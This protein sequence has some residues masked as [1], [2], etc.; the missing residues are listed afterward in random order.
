M[1]LTIG[2]KMPGKVGTSSVKLGAVD[3]DDDKS[4]AVSL[5]RQCDLLL[6][7]RLS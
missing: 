7:G 3:L 1:L 4:N 2:A 5:A 6:E